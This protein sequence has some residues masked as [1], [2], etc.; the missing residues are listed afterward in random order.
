MSGKGRVKALQCSGVNELELVEFEKPRPAADSAVLRVRLCGICGSDIH[1]IEGKRKV[2][3]PFI[4]GHE[5]VADV[6]ELGENARETIKVF[7]ENELKAGDR[8]VVNPRII[9]G[10]CFFCTNFPSRQELCMNTITATSIGSAFPPHLLG[11]WGE[12]LYVLPHSDLIRIPD[13]LSDEIAVLAEPF[14]C[15]TGC[16]DRYRKEHE[17]RAGDAFAIEEP[18]VVI[19]AGAIGILL[20]RLQPGRCE[21]SHRNR[22]KSRKIVAFERIRCNERD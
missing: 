8:V 22:F 2:K 6:D 15:A 4:P 10:R 14:T 21:D 17:W 7:G 12:Y 11:G 16:V 9:C 19:G 3:Y 5:I 20:V 18:V 13:T 1:G